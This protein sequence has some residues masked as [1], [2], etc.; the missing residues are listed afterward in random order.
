VCRT[1]CKIPLPDFFG[2][3]QDLMFGTE[4]VEVAVRMIL[5]YLPLSLVCSTIGE[6]VERA[7]KNRVADVERGLRELLKDPDSSCQVKE[8]Y[9]HG[10]ISGRFKVQSEPG[11]LRIA[12]RLGRL[13][14]ARPTMVEHLRAGAPLGWFISAGAVS[15]GAPFWLDTLNKFIVVRS[16]IKPREKSHEE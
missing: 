5:T 11:A 7:L 16:T 10:M 1:Q 12:D 8:V 2:T 15:F 3:A 4:I 9:N 13:L 14:R 6:Q